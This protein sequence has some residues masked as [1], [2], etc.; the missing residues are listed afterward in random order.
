VAVRNVVLPTSYPT[1]WST[2]YDSSGDTY[3]GYAEGAAQDV[4]LSNGQALNPNW[5]LQLLQNENPQG[6]P[7]LELIGTTSAGSTHA[8]GLAQVEPGT[9]AQYETTSGQPFDPTNP[10]QSIDFAAEYVGSLI[11]KFLSNGYS[12]QQ[13]Y[14]KAAVAYG[15]TA[16][17]SPQA[18]AYAGN[19]TAA[20]N[21]QVTPNQVSPISAITGAVN[22]NV[23]AFNTGASYLLN[24]S[25]TLSGLQM[26]GSSAVNTVLHPASVVSNFNTGAAAIGAAGTQAATAVAS[27]FA[28]VQGLFTSSFAERIVLVLLGLLLIGAAIFAL[29]KG[30]NGNTPAIVP[31]PI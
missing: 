22:D 24:P 18:S 7:G 25:T 23:S 20:L 16:N 6:N 19:L 3:A 26:I 29:S 14:S 1:G 4:T 12:V 8:V 28:W 15:D 5:L 27:P 9:A 13:A 30:S 21:M 11:S 2:P 31:V 17:N 10:L